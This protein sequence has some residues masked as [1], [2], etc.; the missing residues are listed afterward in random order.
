M[1]MDAVMATPKGLRSASSSLPP[2]KAFI[3]VSP[4][5]ARSQAR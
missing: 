1:H 5:S 3:T 4:T 2:A